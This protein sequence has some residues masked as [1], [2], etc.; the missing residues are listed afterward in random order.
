MFLDGGP[1]TL[2]TGKVV[3]IGKNYRAKL[4]EPVNISE[5]YPVVFMKPPCSL[6]PLEEPIRVPDYSPGYY[7]AELAVLIG[8]ELH[9]SNHEQVKKGVAGYA[10]A[11]DLTLKELLDQLKRAGRPWELAK[12]FDRSC[13]ISP[14]VATDQISDPDNTTIHLTINGEIR[15]EASTKLMIRTTF[16]LISVISDYVTL[17]PGD[18][19]LTGTPE[20]AGMLPSKAVLTLK[21]DNRYSFCTSVL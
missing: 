9:R 14:F 8:S 17:L 10:I 15:Q 16:E 11:L 12:S 3:C 1:S 19:V 6:A 18:V 2:E 4:D 21:L 20:G 5:D 13:P 7:E